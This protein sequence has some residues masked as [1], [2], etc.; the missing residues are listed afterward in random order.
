HAAPAAAAEAEAAFRRGNVLVDEGDYEAALIEYRRSL[1][2]FRTRSATRNVA[3]ALRKLKRYD[4]ALVALQTLA[5]EFPPSTRAE[6]AAL[7]AE[8]AQLR[9][10]V[11]TLRITSNEAGAVVTVDDVPRGETPLASLSLATGK[12]RVRVEKPGF[13]TIERTV[14]LAG[15]TTSD[16]RFQLA[17]VPKVEPTAI[18]A[19]APEAPRG[20]PVASKVGF[21]AIGLGLGVGV[22]GGVALALREER[23][24]EMESSG[25][26][27]AVTPTTAARCDD[28]S[29]AAK[30]RGTL[31]IVSF[32]VAGALVATGLV[33][34]VVA[35]RPKASALSLTCTPGLGASCVLKF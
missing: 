32:A 30:T 10:L 8:I 4:E 26:S 3:A 28:L 1:G 25:C 34:Q 16:Q 7:E 18:A 13:V 21:A 23:I 33:L 20:R 11:G 29:S 12:H 15:Q 6:K 2:L 14:E 9:M 22:L 24:G 27:G 35:P 19:S 5:R 31:A 17:P